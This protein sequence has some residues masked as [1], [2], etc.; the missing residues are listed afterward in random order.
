[1]AEKHI[2]AVQF[3]DV[4]VRQDLYTRLLR[5]LLA[6]CK[7]PIAVHEVHRHTSTD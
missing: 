7:V 4:G 1:M 6:N 2:L 5:E 3:G